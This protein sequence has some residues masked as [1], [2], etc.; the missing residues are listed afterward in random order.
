MF[1]NLHNKSHLAGDIYSFDP[2][3][4]EPYDL[5]MQKDNASKVHYRVV[6]VERE[7]LC[8]L[9]KKYTYFPDQYSFLDGNMVC[10]RF[11]GRK[12]DVS[13]KKNVMA[14]VDFLWSVKEGPQFT[15]D[16]FI[17]TG[18]MYTDEKVTNVWRHYETGQPPEDPLSWY[19]GEPNGGKVENCA[20]LWTRIDSGKKGSGFNDA[21]CT[22]KVPVACEDV[23][24]VKLTLRGKMSIL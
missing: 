19:F 16:Q 13:T 2:D 8:N 15:Q 5:E 22:E 11:G 12:A 17:S 24:L 20:Q 10:K 3:D 9:Q 1:F 21:S 18:T 14:L 6:E 7:I 4:W 23:G